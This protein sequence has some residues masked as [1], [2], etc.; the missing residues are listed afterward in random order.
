MSSLTPNN[1]SN[2]H[3]PSNESRVFDW[4]SVGLSL[5]YLLQLHRL[6]GGDSPRCYRDSDGSVWIAVRGAAGPEA[7]A[8]AGQEA[9]VELE[10][11]TRWARRG[12]TAWRRSPRH[13]VQTGG[14]GREPTVVLRRDGLWEKGDPGP[15]HRKAPHTPTMIQNHSLTDIL[16]TFG[17]RQ[18]WFKWTLSITH[19]LIM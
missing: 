8:W 9:A 4:A 11:M 13:Y 1:N 2:K 17:T 14:R 19:Y 12:R 6:L 10:D 18:F 3:Q 15:R 5:S 16:I 7:A